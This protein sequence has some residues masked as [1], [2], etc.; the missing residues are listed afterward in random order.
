MQLHICWSKL[1]LKRNWSLFGSFLGKSSTVLWMRVRDCNIGWIVNVWGV[2]FDECKHVNKSFYWIEKDRGSSN[3][4]KS[5]K[6]IH[7]SKSALQ[8]I[9][10]EGTYKYIIWKTLITGLGTAL[11]I[12][13]SSSSDDQNEGI[14]SLNQVFVNSSDAL[15]DPSMSNLNLSRN[16]IV[17]LFNAFGRLSTSIQQLERFRRM[18]SRKSNW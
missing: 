1:S 3:V 10:L 7:F 11:K 18:L 17:A 15:I 12:L 5:Q 2:K 14:S 4:S 9:F 13:F 6:F 16:E 8:K